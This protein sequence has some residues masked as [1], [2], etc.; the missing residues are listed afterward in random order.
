MRPPIS[1][2]V[3]EQALICQRSMTGQRECPLL[4]LRPEKT[5]FV[6]GVNAAEFAREF[7]QGMSRTAIS[8]ITVRRQAGIFWLLF[9]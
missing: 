9:V 2:K 3:V 6:A 5:L 1:K 4:S 8:S 7:T